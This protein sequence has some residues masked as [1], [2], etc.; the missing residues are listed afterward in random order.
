MESDETTL[1]QA[2]LVIGGIVLGGVIIS[3]LIE[4]GSTRE[5]RSYN[6]K[7]TKQLPNLSSQV[8][9]GSDPTTQY[10]V[11]VPTQIRAVSRCEPNS[12]S[13]RKYPD[14]YYS[15]S[16]NQQYKYRQ[17]MSKDLFEISQRTNA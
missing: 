15:L 11:Q 5:T 8:Q 14:T 13:E 12:E 16:K 2:L 9:K 3:E 7:S 4:N 6:K 17:K 1:G 10:I